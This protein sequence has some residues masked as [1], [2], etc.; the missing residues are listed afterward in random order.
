MWKWCYRETALIE[1][2]MRNG[3][4][5]RW[6]SLSVPVTIV[7]GGGGGGVVVVVVDYVE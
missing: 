4:I 5:N 3:A 1:L 6:L 7:A 2:E